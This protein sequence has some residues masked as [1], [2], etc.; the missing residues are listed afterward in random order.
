MPA[1]IPTRT[2]EIALPNRDAT[3][4]LA[5]RLAPLLA[6]G[7]VV[8]LWGGLGAGK[9]A[10]ARDLIAARAGAAREVPSPTFTL[11]QTYE[12]DALTI[13]HFDLYRIERPEETIE[14]GFEDALA[15]GTALIE[16]P[17]RLG[18]LLPAER[19]DIALAQGPA[20]E[21]RIA[22]VT[23]RGAWAARLDALAQEA[24]D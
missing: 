12:L 24:D 15:E 19:L 17:D 23:G 2:I 18:E 21:A 20:P 16:W 10:F 3:R 1:A 14:L 4:R 7:D 8:A 9:T 6:A 5:A 11:V 22:R 13:W